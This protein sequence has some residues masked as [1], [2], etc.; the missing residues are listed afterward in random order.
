MELMGDI[1]EHLAK[2]LNLYKKVDGEILNM[3]LPDLS[4]LG[5]VSTLG[6][7]AFGRVT[8]VKFEE[9]Y[10]ALKAM[11]KHLITKEG[12]TKHV[13]SEKRALLDCKNP[14]IVNLHKTYSDS[15]NVYMLM[16]VVQ[17]GELFAYLQK[18]QQPLSEA[19]ARFYVA[20]VILALDHM[21]SKGY[22]YRDLKPENLLI[23]KNGY[24]KLADL[25]FAKRLLPGLKTATMCGTPEYLAPE[26][27]M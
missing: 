14:F 13:L 20:G 9:R 15:Q 27:V 23:D 22:A 10:F 25:G 17:G 2:K 11:S 24:I 18:R 3:N 21:H 8:L 5:Y 1:G 12:L 26:I 4:Q 6:T 19:Q 7:G 16:D